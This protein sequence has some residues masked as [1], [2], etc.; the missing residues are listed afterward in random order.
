MQSRYYSSD[1]LGHACAT[2]PI[3]SFERKV[4]SKIG[5]LNLLQLSMDGPNVKWSAYEKLQRNLEL[6]NHCQLID[7]GSCGLHKIYNAFRA[8]LNSTGWDIGHKF[9]ALRTL[10][11]D[12]LARPEEYGS[13]TKSS[14]Y[15]LPFCG[16]R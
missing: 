3:K 12:V 4:E 13:V 7:I 9:S 5:L 14:C 2:V 15:P 11:E 10:F 8:G 6:Q 16:H 1:F